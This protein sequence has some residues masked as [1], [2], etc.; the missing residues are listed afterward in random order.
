[1][2]MR[3]REYVDFD[4]G[5]RRDPAATAAAVQGGWQRSVQDTRRATEHWLRTQGLWVEGESVPERMRR[6]AQYRARLARTP[7]PGAREWAQRLIERHRA[8]EP[9]AP[10]ALDAA[11]D[12]LELP[13][14][15]HLRVPD[16]PVVR[17]DFRERQAG[18]AEPAVAG[19]DD[20]PWGAWP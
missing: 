5:T 17:P 18:D 7:K 3:T 1:M 6:L 10:T 4:G 2:T 12:L 9:I 19:A 11:T 13:R 14:A 8:G 16:P 20:D 15:M